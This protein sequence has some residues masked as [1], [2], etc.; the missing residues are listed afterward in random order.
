MNT[1]GYND[2]TKAFQLQ[3]DCAILAVS[4]VPEEYEAGMA[5]DGQTRE[6]AL[7][8]HTM[9]VRQLI[10]A[11]NKM[12]LVGWSEDKFKN[13][14]KDVSEMLSKIGYKTDTVAFVPVSFPPRWKVSVVLAWPGLIC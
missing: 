9:G 5:R 10:V 12:D 3:A 13:V 14:Q 1:V 2:I 11:V 7:L 8:A 4:A 6:H